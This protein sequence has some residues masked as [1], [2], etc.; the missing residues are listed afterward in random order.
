MSRA[1]RL[2]AQLATARERVSAVGYA[3][4]DERARLAAR[5]AELAHVVEA[6]EVSHRLAAMALAR[7]L[8]G[9]GRGLGRI[10]DVTP[11]PARVVAYEPRPSPVGQVA[12]GANPWARVVR[13]WGAGW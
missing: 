5:A 1:D 8:R 6:A 11:G 9:T 7:G 4:R 13:R 12:S 3:A 2:A 10:G